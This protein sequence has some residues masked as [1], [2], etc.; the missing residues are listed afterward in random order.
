MEYSL[1][2]LY[3]ETAKD[4]NLDKTN[5]THESTRTPYI[6]SKYLKLYTNYGLRYKQVEK[7][8][9]LLYRERWEYYNGKASEEVY[10]E[11]PFDLKIIRGDLP[12]Y[13]K[14]DEKLSKLEEKKEY[15]LS[16]VNYLERI[17]KIIDNRNWS[18]RNMIEWEKFK[19][20]IV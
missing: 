4:L 6:Y 10:K 15:F 7:E 16:C 14:A 2:E 19:N 17:L 9:D 5:L 11:E 18:I 1:D 20:G 3:T 13:L 8:Y 12:I